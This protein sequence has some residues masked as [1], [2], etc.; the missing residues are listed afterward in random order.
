MVKSELKKPLVFAVDDDPD[1]LEL[2]SRT[3]KNR[4]IDIETFSSPEVFLKKLKICLP[5]LCLIDLRYGTLRTGFQVIQAVR[6]VLGPHLPLLVASSATDPKMVAHA[7]ELGANDYIIKPLDVDI[8][9]TKLLNYLRSDELVKENFPFFEVPTS[10]QNVSFDIE[11]VIKEIDETGISLRSSHL[12]SKGSFLKLR[13]S[14]IDEIMGPGGSLN[15]NILTNSFDA[16]N[17]LYSSYG[18]IDSGEENTLTALHRW[19]NKKSEV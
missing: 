18:E 7:I 11:V 17:N 16:V 15:I 3:L 4:S 10:H 12:L 6:T 2:I 19:L 8:F 5:S 13:G 14:M 1:F 9:S